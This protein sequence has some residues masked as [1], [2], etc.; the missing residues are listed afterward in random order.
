MT[1][2]NSLPEG[3]LLVRPG[4]GRKYPCGPME[5]HFL[6][7]G[8]ESDDR[9]SVS[10]WYVA[11]GGAGPGPHSHEANEELFLVVEGTIMFQV[12]N[13]HVH[14]PTGTFL[15]VPAGV[16]HDFY[17]TSDQRA[18]VFN[19]FIPGGFERSMPSIVDW[20]RSERKAAP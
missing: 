6:A 1:T 12:G 17:N 15:R 9:Y 3:V 8:P 4:G 18:G 20:F 7:D 5:A 11:A 13:Q 14:A 16:I 19:V 10:I 2:P